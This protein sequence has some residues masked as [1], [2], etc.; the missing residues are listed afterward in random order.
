M[1]SEWLKVMLEE[2]ARKRAASLAAD[3]EAARRRSEHK[4]PVADPPLRAA[5]RARKGKP[6][7]KS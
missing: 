6:S 2:I 7:P 1:T 3:A 5:R 4:M